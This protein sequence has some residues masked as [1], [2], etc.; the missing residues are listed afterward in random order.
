MPN[1]QDLLQGWLVG[2]LEADSELMGLVNG[3]A[4]EAVWGTLASPYV[5]VDYLDG[6]D[7]YVVGLSRVWLDST[8]HVRAVEHWRGSGQPDRTTVNE[9]GARLE[10]LL[11]DH[12]ETTATL[13]VHS[14]REEPTPTPAV[15][16]QNGELWLQSGG[17]YRLRAHAV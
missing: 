3:I 15:T 4:P 9:I 17:I 7:L 12:E 8:F 11:H 14:F 6:E 16:E 5:R 1:E 2:Y 10:E 13:S